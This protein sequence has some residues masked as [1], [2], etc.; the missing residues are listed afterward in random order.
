MQS[1]L[2]FVKQNKN[3]PKRS[4]VVEANDKEVLAMA[5]SKIPDRRVELE[6]KKVKWESDKKDLLNG[7]KYHVEQ[8]NISL[9]KLES[10]LDYT[11]NIQ[12]DLDNIKEIFVKIVEGDKLIK[13]EEENIDEDENDLRYEMQSLKRD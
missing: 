11:G 5:L 8:I 12:V 4:I 3:N 1:F 2:E 7:I 6:A 10:G 13:D 9:G